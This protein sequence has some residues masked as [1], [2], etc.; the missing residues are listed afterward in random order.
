L[1]PDS[2]LLRVT[3]GLQ[4]GGAAGN[5]IDRL[6]FGYV[7][8][9]IDVRWWPIFNVADSSVVIGAILL[10]YYAFVIDRPPDTVHTDQPSDAPRA[11]RDAR[12]GAENTA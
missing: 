4:L 8:D 1:A 12:P 10:A 9:F 2:W 5:L 6:R 7:T 3:F 11:E